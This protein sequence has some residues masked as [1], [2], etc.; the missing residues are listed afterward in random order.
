MAYTEITVDFTGFVLN[1][2]E[3]S[4]NHVV[5]NKGDEY[6]VIDYVDDE[7]YCDIYELYMQDGKL[8]YGNQICSFFDYS[9]LVN[10]D[11]TLKYG[12]IQTYDTVF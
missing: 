6:I 8:K 2:K 12:E 4:Y 3:T 9:E 7:E 10:A 5:Y 1:K 11:S